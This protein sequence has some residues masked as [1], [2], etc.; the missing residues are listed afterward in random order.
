MFQSVFQRFLECVD[1]HLMLTRFPLIFF[2]RVVFLAWVIEVVSITALLAF[3]RFPYAPISLFTW[4]MAV[5]LPLSCSDAQISFSCF[6]FLIVY[7]IVIVSAILLVLYSFLF[8]WV[9]YV[10]YELV[11]AQY[12]SSLFSLLFFK[13]LNQWRFYEILKDS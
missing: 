9:F 5:L 1:G 8:F 6:L 11:Y 10:M 2:N 3:F 7:C 4:T 12:L 13:Y